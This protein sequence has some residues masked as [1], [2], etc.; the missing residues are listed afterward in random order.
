[1]SSSKKNI[2]KAL[3]SELTT[4]IPN[5]IVENI[6]GSYW[7]F[8]QYN[9][10]PTDNQ[11]LVQK[12]QTN[13]GTFNSKKIALSW[14]IANRNNQYT[15]ANE[16]KD[17]DKKIA[18]TEND[19]YVRSNIANKSDNIELKRIVRSKMELRISQ[20]NAME[21]RLKKCINIVKYWQQ[22]GFNNE[23]TRTR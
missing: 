22:R 7:V 9:I 3:K 2:E 15:L 20:K 13:I 1:M 16:L 10:I 17:L 23:T 14:C 6:D 12:S 4:M 11:F 18:E 5:I 21:A 19:I 8:G